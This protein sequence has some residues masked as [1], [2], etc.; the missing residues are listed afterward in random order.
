MI[1]QYC[2]NY[3]ASILPHL[4]RR[5]LIMF[6]LLILVNYKH[7]LLRYYVYCTNKIPFNYI[8]IFLDDSLACSFTAP[9]QIMS[10]LKTWGYFHFQWKCF[11]TWIFRRQLFSLVFLSQG[12]PA[13]RRLYILIII[14]RGNLVV[15]S[16]VD[17]KRIWLEK[18][19]H[20]NNIKFVYRHLKN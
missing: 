10:S 8:T 12:T 14:I 19:K 7:L 3:F 15:S 2:V 4:V 16:I 6:S 18:F 11:E 20:H 17:C 13:C 9:L 1:P 5:F